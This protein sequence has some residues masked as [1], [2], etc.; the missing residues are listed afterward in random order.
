M[1]P[2]GSPGDICVGLLWSVIDVLPLLKRHL[3]TSP[4]KGHKIVMQGSTERPMRPTVDLN[5]SVSECVGQCPLI[6]FSKD[7]LAGTV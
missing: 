4:E 6:I 2:R 1:K 7:V 3:L 5:E